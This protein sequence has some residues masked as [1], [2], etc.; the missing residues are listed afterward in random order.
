MAET[1][2]STAC[3]GWPHITT[4]AQ[5]IE[6]NYMKCYTFAFEHLI[7]KNEQKFSSQ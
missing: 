6:T 5:Q 3:A 2:N 7:G 1:F 4:M